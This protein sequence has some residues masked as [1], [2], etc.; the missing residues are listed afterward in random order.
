MLRG[1]WD[2]GRAQT[3]TR[4]EPLRCREAHVVVLAHITGAELRRE[5][6]ETDRANGLANRF[7]LIAAKRSPAAVRRQP[8]RRRAVSPPSA[9][10][11]RP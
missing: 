7:L 8:M 2:H 5:L 3:L 11:P 4:H 6:T 1:L 9:T 10:W